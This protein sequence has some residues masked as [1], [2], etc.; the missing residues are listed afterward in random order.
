MPPDDPAARVL[1]P[2]PQKPPH[3]YGIARVEGTGYLELL[4]SWD[5]SN[6]QL[7]VADVGESEDPVR[8]QVDQAPEDRIELPPPR[9]RRRS[10]PARLARRCAGAAP[11]ARTD[12]G[13]AV[14][15]RPYLLTMDQ[16]V[17]LG[18]LNSRE[19]QQR[20]ED[21]YIAALP[22]TLERFAFAAQ[23]FA[24]EQA[25]LEQTGKKRPEGP[26]SRWRLNGTAGFSKVFPT[27]ALL[28]VDYANKTVLNLSGPAAGK[29]TSL[30]TL[31]LDLVQPLLRGGG[32]AVTLEPLTQAERN[33]LYEIRDYSRASA[34]SSTSSSPA[35]ATSTRC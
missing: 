30:G 17:E 10:R 4:R 26:G 31:N 19:F 24:A 34:R 16:A 22:V 25:F 13:C 35:A 9:S 18:V 27:G 11:A 28:L 2:A 32:K 3:K 15:A 20:R 6:R 1:A 33:L 21:L 5:A 29:T 14:P 7:R 8:K 23:F 12:A